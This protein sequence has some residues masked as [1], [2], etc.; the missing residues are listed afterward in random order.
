MSD[1]KKVDPKWY[2][3]FYTKPFKPTTEM[4]EKFC[5]F[6]KSHKI[7]GANYLDYGTGASMHTIIP[8]ANY[9]DDITI[10]YYKEIDGNM[11][12]QWVN[13]DPKAFDWSPWIK[14]LLEYENPNQ[15]ITER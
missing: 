3:Q 4:L 11:A 6:L 13:G 7:H 2:L 8:V 14:F 15:T 12:K 9:Y 10:T 1:Y 5:D